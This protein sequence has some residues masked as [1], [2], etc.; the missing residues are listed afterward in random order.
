M[1][2]RLHLYLLQPFFV[3]N[4]DLLDKKQYNKEVNPKSG[5]GKMKK[6]YFRIGMAISSA[7]VMLG[8]S[9]SCKQINGFGAAKNSD[10]FLLLS[11]LCCM[12]LM[13]ILLLL[14]FKLRDEKQQSVI[15]NMTDAG[16]G[17]GNQ[18]YFEYMFNNT[19]TDFSRKMYHIAYIIIDSSYLE[20]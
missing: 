8:S 18:L 1:L 3:L 16:T 10:L 5:D 12:F 9:V 2:D 17:M 15:N 14:L 19:I 13:G 20:A 11:V 6:F 4:Q 7:L